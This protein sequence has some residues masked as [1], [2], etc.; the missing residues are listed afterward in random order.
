M[1]KQSTQ[2]ATEQ[3][4]SR[5]SAGRPRLNEP[6]AAKMSETRRSQIRRAQ[7]TYR[8]RKEASVQKA[9]TLVAELEQRMGEIGDLLRAYKATLQS[10][11]QDAHPGLI[12]GLDSILALLPAAP[13]EVMRS[14]SCDGPL[15]REMSASV[16]RPPDHNQ[17]AGHFSSAPSD[18]NQERIIQLGSTF[19]A[20]PPSSVTCSR[21]P[22][23]DNHRPAPATMNRHVE[24]DQ[25]IGRSI[26]PHVP[27][28]YSFLESSFTRRLK[29]SSL[30]HAFRIFNDPHSNPLE[31]FRLF[32]LVPC[33]R[34]R[35]K[36]YP[37]FEKLVT[38]SRGHC[39]E[40]L[41][42]PFYTVGGAG[43][44]YPA[45]DQKGNPISPPGARI[46]RRILGMLPLASAPG[47]QQNVDQSQSQRHL[48][49]CGFGGEWFDCRDVEGYL[50]ARGVDLDGSSVF[51]SVE[52]R[53]SPDY[54]DRSVSYADDPSMSQTRLDIS[55]SPQ[56][57]SLHVLDLQSFLT[58][59][60]RGM[61]ILGRAP[62]FRRGDVESEFQLALLRGD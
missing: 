8:Q 49:L 54:S 29:R 58:G 51:P 52:V 12:D 62:G 60:L 26:G 50:R 55:P 43:T 22:E 13:V 57:S 6:G 30:E 17:C 44:H 10:T 61:A 48:E 3:R 25:R 14:S 31:V 5:R 46:P 27:Y 34:D 38:S 47:D 18:G 28:T 24:V 53:Y 21:E 36:M 1:P 15:S 32:R 4:R 40:I 2:P 16:P 35:A 33:F 37:F 59:L 23:Q 39:L 20:S 42:L 45:M 19:D 41:S 56:Q 7:K 11:L 9:Q